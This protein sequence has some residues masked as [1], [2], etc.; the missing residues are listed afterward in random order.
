MCWICLCLCLC[1]CAL[2]GCC[3]G[4]CLFV[5]YY[6][7]FIYFLLFQIFGKNL[8][9]VFLE[10]L[11]SFQILSNF[12]SHGQKIIESNLVCIFFGTIPPRWFFHFFEF[13]SP[14]N[15]PQKVKLLS[16]N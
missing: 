12:L 4:M 13:P 11:E 7:F 16:T 15:L 1:L 8:E 5:Y 6:Y 14:R 9:R 3:S 2:H 10:R